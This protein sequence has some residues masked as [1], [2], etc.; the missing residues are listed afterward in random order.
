MREKVTD[1]PYKTS[2]LGALAGLLACLLPFLAVKA[3]RIVNGHNL[4]L[5][6]LRAPAPVAILI[7]IVLL[8]IA[9]T[10]VLRS[11]RQITGALL[12]T[13]AGCGLFVLSWLLIAEEA[14]Q[15]VPPGIDQPAR[16]SPAA[17]FWLFML[18]SYVLLT[19]GLRLLRPA[20]QSRTRLLSAT[21]STVLVG[22]LAILI[23][24]GSLNGLSIMKEFYNQPER[25]VQALGSHLTI[26]GV[27]VLVAILIGVPLGI[28]AWRRR[29][30]EH[31]IFAVVN[32]IQTIPSLALFGI[33]IA[34]L[35]LLS[36]TFPFLQALG[37]QGIGNAPAMIAITLYALLPI[38]RNTYTSL[39]VI[40]RAIIDSGRGM[41]MGRFQML[42]FVEIPLSL[43]IILGGIRISAVQA[44]G[45][46][47]V[48]ALIG[49]GGLGIFVF[50]GLGQAA[51]DLILLGVVPI[52]LLA[53]AVDR[54]MKAL[55]ELLT[56]RGIRLPDQTEGGADD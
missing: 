33:M 52:I 45:N 19:S 13:A 12:A 43:P 14:A 2:L 18:A 29:A 5:W 36:R 51:P 32:G 9:A 37:I 21:I 23:A 6:N 48:A 15:L 7:L 28:I 47:A 41:G 53:V 35:A 46:T 34:P 40:D 44:V 20:G 8:S 4:A 56:P 11:R 49:A 54:I 27:S 26:A 3:N 42:R 1:T 22:L 25:F 55:V 16:V 31:S 17:G 30:L 24:S 39:S 50:Q 38:T 10:L